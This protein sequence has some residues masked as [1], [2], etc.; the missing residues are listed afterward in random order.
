M[1]EKWNQVEEEENQMEEEGKQMKR[2][3]T[4]GMRKGTRWKRKETDGREFKIYSN[5]VCFGTLMFF[6]RNRRQS[7]IS[8]SLL[9]VRVR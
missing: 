1:E 6:L 8:F 3:G 4:R 9:S 2:K 5:S 7:I